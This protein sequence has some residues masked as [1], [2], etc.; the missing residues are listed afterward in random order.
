[1]TDPDWLTW[2]REMQAIAQTGLTFSKDPYDIERY[3]Q[4]RTLAS[5]IMATHTGADATR[6]E[7]LFKNEQGYTTPKLDVRGAVFNAS[8]EL[9][10]VREAADEGRWTLP[11][12]WADINLTPAENVLKEI[13]E[14]S[15]YEARV[16]K[17]AA[18]LDRTRQGH[19]PLA[20]S[21]AKCFFVCTLTG[22]ASA[23]SL[24][25]SGTGWF[26]R[27]NVP[28]DLSE[29]R[30][31]RSQVLRMFDHAADPSLPADFE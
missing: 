23:T 26:A 14:E 24:E 8:G 12:G 30:T 9:L 21:V 17:L 27:A 6:I 7:T 28:Y 22:G 31:R 10:L 11:G 20:F 19:G 29:G 2:T 13:R 3:E 25:T 5:R 18:V 16:V 15:G 4:L 1:M